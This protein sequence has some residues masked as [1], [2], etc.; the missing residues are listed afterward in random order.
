MAKKF[1]DKSLL[2]SISDSTQLIT[3]TAS[4]TVNSVK[5]SVLKSYVVDS[6]TKCAL[7]N[8]FIMYCR[9]VESTDN[10]PILSRPWDWAAKQ[11]K[12]EKAIGVAIYENGRWLVTA[13][14]EKYLYWG[15]AATSSS[16][17]TAVTDTDVA[18]ADFEGKSKTKTIVLDST[19]SG[20][21][22]APGYCY[23]YSRLNG[24]GS[25]IAA[26]QWWLPSFGELCVM[27]N[28][29]YKIN[30]CLS[31]ISGATQLSNNWYWSSTEYSGTAAWGLDFSNGYVG[32]F[33]NK[34]PYQGSVRP[35]SAF[36]GGSRT[37]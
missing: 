11:T 37:W 24:N 36:K 19:T 21:S 25:G 17:T 15:S 4:G 27:Y 1:S 14:D 31:L 8:V 12:G 3:T 34:A 23:N 26:N 18:S 16:L 20:E 9:E 22:Y 7:D 5:A 30:Y 29:M 32:R 28:N 2:T 33:S 35:V 6:A 13:P 10:Y